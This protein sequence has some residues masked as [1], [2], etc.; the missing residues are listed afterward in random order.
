[1][2]SPDVKPI[3]YA[4][5]QSLILRRNIRAKPPNGSY[6]LGPGRRPADV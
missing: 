2:S 6:E 5:L 4:S 1:M 3:P